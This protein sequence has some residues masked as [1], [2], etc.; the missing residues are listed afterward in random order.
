MKF[1]IF[2]LLDANYNKEFFI[3]RGFDVEYAKIV[4]DEVVKNI[5]WRKKIIQKYLSF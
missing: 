5:R 3:N 2:D 1:A 4:D